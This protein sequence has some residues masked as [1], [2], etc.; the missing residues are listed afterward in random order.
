VRRATLLPLLVRVGIFLCAMFGF[1]VAYPPELLGG[2]LLL[3]LILV[4]AAPAL[5]PRGGAGTITAILMIAGWIMDTTWYGEPVLAWR[6]VALAAALYLGHS[7]T[8]LGA[9]LPYDAT[10]ELN[11]L[12]GWLARALAVVLAS[13]MFIVLVVGAIR[14][15]DESPWWAGGPLL[16]ATIAGLA[17]A[18]AATLLLS[19]LLRRG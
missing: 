11:V 12:T 2:R 1:A 13:S 9:V 16:A 18:T 8:A 17:A 4:A 14:L 15:L 6:I 19:R 5:L 10:V 3:P 7:L